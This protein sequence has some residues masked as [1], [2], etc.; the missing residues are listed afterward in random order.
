MT[1]SS[2]RSVMETI[3][4][5][6]EMESLRIWDS[7]YGSA[8]DALYI[9]L[10]RRSL[11]RHPGIALA[12][13]GKPCDGG[14]IAKILRLDHKLVNACLT[15][16]NAEGL[17][18]FDANRGVLLPKVSEA[19]ALCSAEQTPAPQTV[20]SPAPAPAPSPAPVAPPTP[21]PVSPAVQLPAD[22]PT[23]PEEQLSPEVLAMR[24]KRKILESDFRTYFKQRRAVGQRDA[25]PE[26]EEEFWQYLILAD[27]CKADGSPID[28]QG[29]KTSFIAW[30]RNRKREDREF[31]M[32]QQEKRKAEAEAEAQRKA[33]ADAAEALNDRMLRY[34]YNGEDD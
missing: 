8:A 18:D 31:T 27:F 32:K 9:A 22:P 2:L 28:K 15:E 5:E 21:K 17:V 1:L 14:E 6:A 25:T 4:P 33:E 34:D 23:I 13:N 11:A 26:N 16:L 19:A 24:E 12:K 3:F 20:P 30:M 10:V 29:L 7:R